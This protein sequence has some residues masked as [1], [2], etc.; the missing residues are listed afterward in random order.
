MKSRRILLEEIL[1]TYP[2]STPFQNPHK[3]DLVRKGLPTLTFAGVTARGRGCDWEKPSAL[4]LLN[5]RVLGDRTLQ[6]APIF[7]FSGGQRI[8]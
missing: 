8:S 3:L 2:G 7:V 6:L 4:S 5:T 1:A